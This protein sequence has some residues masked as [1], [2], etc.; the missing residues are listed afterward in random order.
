MGVPKT[1][2]GLKGEDTRRCP[3]CGSTK[4]SR[5]KDELYCEECGFVMED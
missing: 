4:I 5:E 2:Q 3:E 1:L